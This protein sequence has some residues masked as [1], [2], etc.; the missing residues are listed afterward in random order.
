MRMFQENFKQDISHTSDIVD[1]V[2]KKLKDFD[3]NLNSLKGTTNELNKDFAVI[4]EKLTNLD[5]SFKRVQSY[6]S[7]S[8][9]E[10]SSSLASSI[11]CDDYSVF[12]P[13]SS[14]SGSETDDLERTFVFVNKDEATNDISMADY[15]S[16]KRLSISSGDSGIESPSDLV[17][18]RRQEYKRIDDTCNELIDLLIK[19]AYKDTSQSQN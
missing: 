3:L 10:S 17:R 1:L 8:R 13:S 5:S 2:A 19:N 15:E 14:E 9:T 11:S 16:F 4:E 6:S 12:S 7:L 18:M